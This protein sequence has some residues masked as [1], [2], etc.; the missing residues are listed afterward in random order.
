[1]KNEFLRLNQAISRLGYCS[2]RKADELIESGKVL[3]NNQPISEF[4]YKVD[5]QV[6]KIKVNNQ[7]LE[8]KPCTY[9]LFNKPKDI[10]TT[11]QDDS[12]R[13]TIIDILPLEFKHLKPVGR[14]DRK[15]TGL[16]ILTDD[17]YFAN[18]I[19]HPSR[20]IAKKY[21]VKVSGC[22]NHKKIQ[23]LACGIQLEEGIT[24]P[25]QVKLLSASKDFSTFEI[26]IFEGKNRQIRRMCEIIGHEVKALMRI[27]IGN[28]KLNSLKEGQYRFLSKSEINSLKGL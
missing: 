25:A 16:I 19:T 15:T 22:L 12:Q 23:N 14:L 5:V 6:D 10:I 17:G 13:K 3:V 2:R 18:A 20:H 9:L 1:M 7:V 8:I 21:Y 4:N 28:L 24:S 27:G 11:C 26:E